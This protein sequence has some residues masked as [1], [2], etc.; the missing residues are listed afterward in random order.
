M[1]GGYP[2][3]VGAGVPLGGCPGVGTVE[4]LQVWP[5]QLL[6]PT[7]HC[8]LGSSSCAFDSCSF[9]SALLIN[10]CLFL[11]T[12]HTLDK[13]KNTFPGSRNSKTWPLHVYM[14]SE[15][16]ASVPVIA[17]WLKEDTHPAEA[18]TEDQK[19]PSHLEAHLGRTTLLR[20]PGPTGTLLRM[21]QERTLL[22]G[23]EPPG[24]L[25]RMLQESSAC[26]HTSAM[27]TYL[28]FNDYSSFSLR[29]FR[30]EGT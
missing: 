26:Y 29:K 9:N 3:R 23:P 17:T 7:G 2:R 24:T 18:E 19:T 28:L 4:G 5:A 22:R 27:R 10:R 20:G 21:L 8:P 13:W 16:Q 12:K 11:L 6:G 25:P 15:Q 1:Q 30:K 14:S